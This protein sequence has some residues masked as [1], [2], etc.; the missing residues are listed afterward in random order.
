MCCPRVCVTPGVSSATTAFASS[1]ICRSF[2][3]KSAF[4]IR[5][6]AKNAES[7]TAC[8]RAE[9]RAIRALDV[10][11]RTLRIRARPLLEAHDPKELSHGNRSEERRRRRRQ[12]LGQ[13]GLQ[14]AHEEIRAVGQGRQG[15]A[16][17]RAEVRGRK[18][19]AGRS[20]AH[21]QE[22]REEV[23]YL[24]PQRSPQR[25]EPRV[26]AAAGDVELVL[27]RVLLVVVLVVVLRRVERARLGDRREERLLEGLLLLP[28]RLGSFGE[29]LLLVRVVEDLRPVLRA[30]IAELAVG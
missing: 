17:R 15:G 16:R 5:P 21:R 1:S 26:A 9:C 14:R 29:L 30:G 7:L 23:R 10:T 25:V 27:Q 12:L 18:A 4:G 6:P 22:A 19:R 3:M 13:Q 28:L 24:L 2:A 20:R 8:A 11:D